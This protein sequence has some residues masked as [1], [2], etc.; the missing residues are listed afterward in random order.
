MKLTNKNKRMVWNFFHKEG[1]GLEYIAKSKWEKEDDKRSASLLI[2]VM[3]SG[4]LSLDL[5]FISSGALQD[6]CHVLRL[7]Y[8]HVL[9]GFNKMR[10]IIEN[11]E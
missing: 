5:K 8:E 10:K 7:S 9:Y 6:L 3:E 11:G 4:M 1:V 2:A